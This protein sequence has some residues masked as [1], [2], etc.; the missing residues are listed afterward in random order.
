MRHAENPNFDKIILLAKRM[1]T[2]MCIKAAGKYDKNV[3]CIYQKLPSYILDKNS[4][5]V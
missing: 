3:H 5:C 1:R 2:T 4:I